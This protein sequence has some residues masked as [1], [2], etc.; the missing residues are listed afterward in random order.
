MKVAVMARLLAEGDVDVDTSHGLVF[1]V[2]L[3]SFQYLKS[4]QWSVI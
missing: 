4:K 2:Q 3:F 1:S